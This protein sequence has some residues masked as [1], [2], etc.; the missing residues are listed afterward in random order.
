MNIRVCRIQR[1]P[2]GPFEQGL[3]INFNTRN[4][5][6]L[7]ADGKVLGALWHYEVE[8]GKVNLTLDLS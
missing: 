7:D 1:I 4:A 5:L 6:I 3:A 8:S 2:D